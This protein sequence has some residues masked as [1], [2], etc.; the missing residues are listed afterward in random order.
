MAGDPGYQSWREWFGEY[1]GKIKRL[2]QIYNSIRGKYW[3][4]RF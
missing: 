4:R 3:R 1:G 2:G